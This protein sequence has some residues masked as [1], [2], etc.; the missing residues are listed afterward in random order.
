MEVDL[1]KYIGKMVR[2]FKGD[3][4]LVENVVNHYDTKEQLV[5]CKE[6][7]G[8]CKSFA[9]PILY[10]LGKVD[11]EKYPEYNSEYNFVSVSLESPAEIIIKQLEQMKKA[12]SEN[13]VEEEK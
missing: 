7:H 5:V 1:S 12:E 3:Y 9:V 8:N 2:H 4:L 11:K 6:L 10:F 13:K